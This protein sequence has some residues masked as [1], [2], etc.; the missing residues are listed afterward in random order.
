[1]V[2]TYIERLREKLEKNGQVSDVVAAPKFVCDIS[3]GCTLAGN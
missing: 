1:M 3:D 2:Q